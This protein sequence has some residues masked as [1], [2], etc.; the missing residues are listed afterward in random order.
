[1][2]S[3]SSSFSVTI[4]GIRKNQVQCQVSW[5]RTLVLFTS[6]LILLGALSDAVSIRESDVPIAPSFTTQISPVVVVPAFNSTGRPEVYCYAVGNPEPSKYELWVGEFFLASSTEHQSEKEGTSAPPISLLPVENRGPLLDQTGGLYRVQCKA[7]GEG[8]GTSVSSSFFVQVINVSPHAFKDVSVTSGQNGASL[9]LKCVDENLEKDIDQS[10]AISGDLR[11]RITW[12]DQLGRTI[13]ARASSETE[14][15]F[16]TH[17]GDLALLRLQASEPVSYW[18]LLDETKLS[19]ISVQIINSEESESEQSEFVLEPRDTV[20]IAHS[21][22]FVQ[23]DCIGPNGCKPV[24]FFEGGRI[25]QEASYHLKIHR[26]DISRQGSYSCGCISETEVTHSE[27]PQ[28]LPQSI[29]A[30]RLKVLPL[31]V[32]Y[33]LNQRSFKVRVFDKLEV[34]CTLQ[35]PSALGRESDQ[36]TDVNQ[37]YSFGWYHNGYKFKRMLEM[38][39]DDKSGGLVVTPHS[40]NNRTGGIFHCYAEPKQTYPT[41]P[42]VVSAPVLIQIQYEET[43][44][45][46]L[47]DEKFSP[48]IEGHLVELNCTVTGGSLK[49]SVTWYLDDQLIENIPEHSTTKISENDEKLEFVLV[50]REVRVK[51]AGLYKCVAE[52][53]L[54]VMRTKKTTESNQL[55][56]KVL[57]RTALIEGVHNSWAPRLSSAEM[58]C[59]FRVDSTLLHMTSSDEIEEAEAYSGESELEKEERRPLFRILW[60]FWPSSAERE[61]EEPVVYEEN[62]WE[63]QYVQVSR[64]PV[65]DKNVKVREGVIDGTTIVNNSLYIDRIDGERAGIYTCEVDTIAGFESSSGN[66][67]VYSAPS[68]PVKPSV[69]LFTTNRQ[70]DSATLSWRTVA[71]GNSPISH[72]IVHFRKTQAQGQDII[73]EEDISWETFVTKYPPPSSDMTKVRLLSVLKPWSSYVFKVQLNN[74]IGYGKFSDLSNPVVIPES[75]PDRAPDNVIATAVNSTAVEV[76]FSPVSSEHA[77]GRIVGYHVEYG[78][79]GLQRRP[80]NLEIDSAYAYL[81]VISKL[82]V[83]ETVEI[84]VAGRTAKGIGPLSDKVQVRTLEDVPSKNIKLSFDQRDVTSTSVKV[85]WSK[86]SSQYWRGPQK[87]Y[88]IYVSDSVENREIEV[89]PQHVSYTIQDLK[90]FTKYRISGSLFN[91]FHYPEKDSNVLEVTTDESTAGP[92]S[93]IRLFDVT[94]QSVRLVWSEPRE[95]NGV[96]YA[97][98][99]ELYKLKVGS[100]DETM[101]LSDPKVVQFVKKYSSSADKTEISIPELKQSSQYVVNIM[102]LTKLGKGENTVFS[103]SSSVPPTLPEPPNNIEVVNLTATAACLQF[104]HGFSGHT[105]INTWIVEVKMDSRASWT[106]ALRTNVTDKPELTYLQLH[107]GFLTP[108]THYT[109][110]ITSC[111][112]VGCSRPSATSISF[113]TQPDLPRIP[114]P[115]ILVRAISST[116]VEVAWSLLSERDWNDK[117]SN[118]RFNVQ[119]SSSSDSGV[120]KKIELDTKSNETAIRGLKPNKMYTITVMAKNSRGE[121]LGNRIDA[122]TFESLPCAPSSLMH[123]PSEEPNSLIVGWVESSQQCQRGEILYYEAQLLY[124]QKPIETIKVEVSENMMAKFYGLRSNLTYYAQ[125][126]A[127]NGAGKGE[128]SKPLKKRAIPRVP[129]KPENAWILMHRGPPCSFEVFGKFFKEDFVEQIHLDYSFN[130]GSEVTADSEVKNA[131]DFVDVE[132]KWFSKTI[133]ACSDE[134]SISVSVFFSNSLGNSGKKLFSTFIPSKGAEIRLDAFN[135]LNEDTTSRE[136]SI[137][138]NH[139]EKVKVQNFSLSVVHLVDE[140]TND[141]PELG[142][143]SYDNSAK[144][145]GLTP[146]QKYEITIAANGF[147]GDCAKTS[148]I[149]TTE[150]DIPDAIPRIPDYTIKSRRVE[151]SGLSVSDK[152]LNGNLVKYELQYKLRENSTADWQSVF[153]SGDSSRMSSGRQLQLNSMYEMR[154]AVCN[155]MGRGPWTHLFYV[156]V[157]QDEITKPPRDVKVAEGSA[158]ASFVTLSWHH[159]PSQ[160][161]ALDALNING[162]QVCYGKSQLH[163]ACELRA[164]GGGDSGT[165]LT[166]D[167]LVGFTEYVFQVGAFNHLGLGP[168]SY[169]ITVTTDIGVPSSVSK[170]SVDVLT[171][172]LVVVEWSSPVPAQGPIEDYLITYRAKSKNNN[173]NKR[174]RREVGVETSEV[175]SASLLASSFIT[176]PHLT[177]NSVTL[178]DLQ[179][180][181]TYSVSIRAK[182]REGFGDPVAHEVFMGSRDDLPAVPGKP[183]FKRSEDG[184]K[185]EEGELEVQWK[186]PDYENDEEPVL[187]YAVYLLYSDRFKTEAVLVDKTLTKECKLVVNINETG[188]PS[189][190]RIMTGLSRSIR[191]SSS[192]SSGY[193]DSMWIAVAAINRNGQGLLGPPSA[194]S[195]EGELDLVAKGVASSSSS[196][197]WY[198]QAWII[199]IFLALFFLLLICLAL[200][201]KLQMTNHKFT[202][203]KKTRNRN[204]IH[205]VILEAITCASSHNSTNAETCKEEEDTMLQRI[206]EA[207]EMQDYLPNSSDLNRNSIASTTV[208]MST[209]SH[210]NSTNAIF[211]SVPALDIAPSKHNMGSLRRKTGGGSHTFQNSLAHHRPMSPMGSVGGKHRSMELGMGGAG[212]FESGGGYMRAEGA[213]TGCDPSEERMEGDSDSANSS[214]HQP[215]ALEDFQPGYPHHQGSRL[216][217][218]SF[219]PSGADSAVDSP[220]ASEMGTFGR[221]HAKRSQ[222]LQ[223][224]TTTTP[225]NLNPNTLSQTRVPLHMNHNNNSN[226][227]VNNNSYS[228]QV[229][230]RYMNGNAIE[231]SPDMYYPP[232][233]GLPG[234]QGNHHSSLGYN[235]SSALRSSRSDSVGKLG[236][237]IEFGDKSRSSASQ[238]PL[239]S[240]R[241]SL[242]EDEDSV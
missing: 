159:S 26:P 119:F 15:S 88:L 187:N 65:D 22:E 110:R 90:P 203:K 4:S 134:G 43:E 25:K 68:S 148:A 209:S 56:L 143:T 225:A 157:T 227:H 2:E 153:S 77:N 205:K 96:I 67:S 21:T 58:H 208:Q 117:I 47:V 195:P 31:V 59:L 167:G 181:H 212:G 111:N 118:C 125:V 9:I 161:S 180:G 55:Q 46:L 197:S 164:V 158:G 54:D 200:C 136:S 237:T 5:K 42:I 87:H 220:L 53:E 163:M 103:F 160:N 66:F 28:E 45:R 38:R 51:Q 146:N 239:S 189:V 193:L 102:A 144:I 229:P 150:P 214:S 172:S 152:K 85:R 223:V 32:D 194:Y 112:I 18:C 40:R 156:F 94:D 57:H 236:A 60:K 188:N 76:T 162:Y 219:S 232:P 35:L 116:E 41:L 230:A 192:S 235:P 114:P 151:L 168:L 39:V 171:D 127:V 24:W 178:S 93:K 70:G 218:S 107:D 98:S 238:V 130:K 141:M 176:D 184:N 99:V 129:E 213:L 36:Q 100:Y 71:D 48:V 240:F 124:N 7:K 13:S 97:Y 14:S 170:L 108:F 69:E 20:A 86:V 19:K 95:P 104:S 6:L 84:A 126:A 74:S 44:V 179:P 89:E 204:Q 83:Y 23:F 16:V 3:F 142:V 105:S 50:L 115:N 72:V 30:A 186:P 226:N 75:T 138:W 173:G 80:M 120:M 61:L 62:S 201:V 64:Q 101:T 174:S 196:E 216:A 140:F 135:N 11:S 199:I 154:L 79:V 122:K 49:K 33:G 191:S 123:R 183:W 224:A 12:V 210:P 128:W 1:M 37:F 10:N 206:H 121:R 132:S 113:Q 27:S 81:V 145:V 73:N 231:R 17:R 185:D 78:Y 137:S 82:G 131:E 52:E 147:F 242:E 155:Q 92:V 241:A 169:P 166:V 63:D 8:L 182:T 207:Q 139:N 217:P 177:S 233:N 228:K 221:S 190:D 234:V 106:H 165:S 34:P 149:I 29:R 198:S 215:D 109:A 202:S 211:N 222:Q 175:D 133:D 91:G